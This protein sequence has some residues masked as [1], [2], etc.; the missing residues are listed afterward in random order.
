MQVLELLPLSQGMRLKER[1]REVADKGLRDGGATG[2]ERAEAELDS[3]SGKFS[4]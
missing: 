2:G 3:W 4:M 1:E